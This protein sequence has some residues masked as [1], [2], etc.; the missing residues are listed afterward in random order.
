MDKTKPKYK[1]KIV[2]RICNQINLIHHDFNVK[3]V[4]LVRHR[5]KILLDNDFATNQEKQD[6]VLDLEAQI[7]DLTKTKDS[8]ICEI[9]KK[10][11]YT[12]GIKP[13]FVKKIMK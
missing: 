8:K 10:Q 6:L 2:E 13:E 11:C 12:N 3:L 7:A 5:K 9:I 1:T 4:K